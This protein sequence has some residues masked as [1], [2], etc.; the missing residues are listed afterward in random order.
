MR[1]ILDAVLICAIAVACVGMF[2]V[3]VARLILG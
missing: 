2:L 3:G 1:D